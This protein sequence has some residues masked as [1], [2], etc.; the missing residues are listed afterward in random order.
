VSQEV[1]PWEKAA[2]CTRA[3]EAVVDPTRLEMLMRLRE[4][5]IGLANERQLLDASEL[6]KQIA[7]IARIHAELIRP[8]AQ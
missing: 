2:E 4:L 3:M 1:D 7:G 6:A 5:W 8:A